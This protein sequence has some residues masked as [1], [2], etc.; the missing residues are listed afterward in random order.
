MQRKPEDV[1]RGGRGVWTRAAA[2][3]ASMAGL[4]AAQTDAQGAPLDYFLH[5]GGPAA[6][7]TMRLGWALAA[8]SMSVI[9]IVALLLAI[10]IARRR[11]AR[12]P[13]TLE[14]G[15]KGAL[16]WVYIGTGISSALLIAALAYTLVTLDSVAAPPHAPSL[17]VTAYDWWWKVD[18]SD[19]D[20]GPAFVTANEIHIP[21]GE[22]RCL[23]L[24]I[25]G[26]YWHFVDLVWL[27]IFTTIYLSPYVLRGRA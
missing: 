9:A 7:P 13:N 19:A 15:E 5:A 17:T 10:A 1:H 6:G 14:Q 11:H 8:L 2:A 20:G 21:V 12:G 26:L 27:F 25:G 24:T 16:R 3:I 4:M 23:A 18:Y 22:K